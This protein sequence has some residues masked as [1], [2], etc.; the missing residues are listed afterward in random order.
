MAPQ[1]TR[2]TTGGCGKAYFRNPTCRNPSLLYSRGIADSDSQRSMIRSAGDVEVPRAR[3]AGA[4]ARD[5][6]ERRLRHRVPDAVVDD[7]KIVATELV[8]NAVIHGDGRITLR[9]ELRDDAV[10][11]EVIDEGTGNAPKIRE[12]ERTDDPGG[13]GLRIVEA[14]STR[15][16]TFEGTTHV[17]A[18]VALVRA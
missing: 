16:G 3:E 7:T 12:Q 8:N 17:W 10:R 13:R 1:H 2:L 5:F 6:I 11:V 4:R 9:A 18:D 15:W 14:L